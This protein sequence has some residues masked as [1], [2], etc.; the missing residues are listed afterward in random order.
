L[1]RCLRGRADQFRGRNRSPK[2]IPRLPL[3]LPKQVLPPTWQALSSTAG[4]LAPTRFD[5]KVS[6]D[7][8]PSPVV[9]FRRRSEEQLWRQTRGSRSNRTSS[10]EGSD[11]KSRLPLRRSEGPSPFPKGKGL[12]AHFGPPSRLDCVRS[13]TPDSNATKRGRYGPMPSAEAHVPKNA[14]AVRTQ[15]TT[16]WPPPEDGC[17]PAPSSPEATVHVQTRSATRL[18]TRKHP[19]TRRLGVRDNAADRRAEAHRSAKRDSD[20]APA[21]DKQPRDE[22]PVLVAEAPISE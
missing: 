7:F 10:P 12:G 14:R 4:L 13:K 20:F 22:D 6:S 2:S 8:F 11:A 1:W 9:L 19:R 15:L 5:P 3:L 16:H 18:D 17:N 21:A